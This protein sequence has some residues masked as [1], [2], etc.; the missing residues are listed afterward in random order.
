MQQLCQF[1]CQLR[2]PLQEF[3]EH[4]HVH[5]P[6]HLLGHGRGPVEVALRQVHHWVVQAACLPVEAHWG[7]SPACGLPGRCENCR[8]FQYFD[9]WGR[10]WFR[11]D[12]VHG[13]RW[14]SVGG[15]LHAK[16]EW[17]RWCGVVWCYIWCLLGEDCEASFARDASVSG[18]AVPTVIFPF[19]CYKL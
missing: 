9:A 3:G 8:L 11:E 5:H 2:V 19:D 16:I 17:L 7:V 18:N 14:P 1:L 6:H 15:S 4:F 10:C 13:G 12:W